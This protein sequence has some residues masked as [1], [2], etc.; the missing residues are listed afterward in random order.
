MSQ[1]KKR[2]SEFESESALFPVPANSQ[3]PNGKRKA[4]EVIAASGADSVEHFEKVVQSLHGTTFREQAK[5]VARPGTE[6]QAKA[7]GSV[8]SRN[9]GKLLGELAQSQHR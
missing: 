8:N 5:D 6:T 4:K 9:L 2:G 7:C 3:H 1:A